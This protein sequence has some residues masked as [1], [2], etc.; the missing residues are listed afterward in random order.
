MGRGGLRTNQFYYHIFYNN[1]RTEVIPWL[2]PFPVSTKHLYNICTMWDLR[3]RRWAD[4]VQMLY[5]CFA[6]ARKSVLRS[7]NVGLSLAHRLGRWP[8]IKPTLGPCSCLLRRD[9][10]LSSKHN[11]LK[12]CWCNVGPSSS[13]LGQHY[14]NIGLASRLDWAL[15][16]LGSNHRNILSY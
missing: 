12:Q 5:E 9:H 2:V 3:R 16:L 13:T 8:S 11:T 7:I 6:F 1:P 10:D 15:S 14:A 4:V